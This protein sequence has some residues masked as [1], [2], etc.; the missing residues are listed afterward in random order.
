MDF[1]ARRWPILSLFAVTACATG[2]PEMPATTS[3]PPVNA[4][5]ASASPGVTS[6]QPDPAGRMAHGDRADRACGGDCDESLAAHGGTAAI[7][8]AERWPF[9]TRVAAHWPGKF[10]LYDMA[11]NVW[12][13]TASNYCPYAHPGCGDPHRVIRGG[14]WSVV[15]FLFVRLTDRSPADPTTRNT[16]LGFRCAR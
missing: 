14:S 10:G 4:L 5:A 11:G 15:D 16:N 9:T 1:S 7:V 6:T 3:A 8:G 2:R 12:E 13:W